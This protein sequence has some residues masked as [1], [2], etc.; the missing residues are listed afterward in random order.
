MAVL[1][2]GPAEPLL[3]CQRQ[4]QTTEEPR[5]YVMLSLAQKC[6]LW[7]IANICISLIIFLAWLTKKTNE[8]CFYNPQCHAVTMYIHI[9]KELSLARCSFSSA[10]FLTITAL[11]GGDSR[12]LAPAPPVAA[13]WLRRQDGREVLKLSYIYCEENQTIRLNWFYWFNR[14]WPL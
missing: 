4:D 2:S 11:A 12:G 9:L 7:S 6:R 3:L 10:H 1:L 14:P 8:I 5:Q 13:W